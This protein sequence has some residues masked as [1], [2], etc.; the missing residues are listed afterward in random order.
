[1]YIYAFYIIKLR[2]TFSYF[3]NCVWHDYDFDSK[4]C[5]IAH[6][7]CR[8]SSLYAST[9]I[10]VLLKNLYTYQE[11]KVENKGEILETNHS[12]AHR[13]WNWYAWD[14]DFENMS[15]GGFQG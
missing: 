14:P 2:N 7:S 8:E 15:S 12:H 4:F 6:E 5:L 13:Y 11:D 3:S 10:Y 1:M 9:T